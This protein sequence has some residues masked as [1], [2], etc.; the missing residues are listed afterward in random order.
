[1]ISSPASRSRAASIWMPQAPAARP[2]MR[3]TSGEN[4]TSLPSRLSIPEIVQRTPRAQVA[5]ARQG[6]MS[7]RSEILRL[8][9]RWLVKR[10]DHRRLPIAQ[11]R[12]FA[13]RVERL[14]PN[15]PANIR[16]VAV[17][18]SGVRA[19]L[20]TTSTSDRHRAILYLHGGA[21]IIGSPA[22]YRHLTW[23]LAAAAGGRVLAA[24]YRLAPEYPF[25]AALDDAV[26]A[27]RWLLADGAEPRR[28]AVIGD[29][30]GRGLVLSLTLTSRDEG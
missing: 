15:P 18:D 5:R 17:D 3:S 14:V 2:A 9:L 16:T 13:A 26:A 10:R 11:H 25:P 6:E 8:A 30:A 22:L 12:R 20:I 27:Y 4:R 29:S 19:D 21:F 1:M 24:D 28:I 23:R 7:V